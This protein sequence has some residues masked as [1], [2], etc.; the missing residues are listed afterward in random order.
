M[1]ENK[2][3]PATTHEEK[4]QP[5]ESEN[6]MPEFLK[7][8][9]DNIKLPELAEAPLKLDPVQKAAYESNASEQQNSD[10]D[11]RE[12][13]PT[14]SE[15][16]VPI[17]G[18]SGHQIKVESSSVKDE[19]PTENKVGDTTKAQ[20]K[21]NPKSKYTYQQISEMTPAQVVDAIS[22]LIQQEEM[23]QPKEIELLKEAFA[24]KKKQL[25]DSA[26]EEAAKLLQETEI[27]ELRL[28]DLVSTYE[29]KYKE[30]KEELT[31]NQEAALSKKQELLSKLEALV[32][33]TDDF[34][35]ISKSFREI[36]TEWKVAGMV[37]EEKV[38]DIQ[39]KYY[40]LREK[41]YD[42]K[43]LND[44]FRQ[45]DFKKNLEAKEELIRKAEDLLNEENTF[46][47]NRAI[48]ELHQCWKDIGPVERELR[49]DL[50]NRFRE[51]SKQV[52]DKHQ[53]V[54]ASRKEEEE[55]NLEAKKRLCEEIEEIQ[56]EKLNSTKHWNDTKTKVLDAQAKWKTI[57]QVPR[58]EADAIYKRFRAAC[59]VFFAK[60]ALFTKELHEEME[61]NLKLKNELVEKAEALA[62]SKDWKRTS[63]TLKSLQE[64]WKKIGQTNYKQNE[65]LWERFRAACNTFYDARKEVLDGHKKETNRINAE[66]RDLTQRVKELLAKDANEDANKIREEIQK[67]VEEYKQVGR[68]YGKTSQQI[69]EDFFEAVNEVYKKWKLDRNSR[70]MSSY[71]DK[72]EQ[73]FES[74]DRDKIRNEITF[75]NHKKERITQE[76]Q[77]IEKNV[78]FMTSSSKWGNNILKDMDTKVEDLRKECA[79]I[80]EK[81][82]LAKQ[83]LVELREAQQQ[84]K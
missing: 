30:Y 60:K 82:S 49:E 5:N 75:L 36:E 57:G 45:Y 9:N 2:N 80:D 41:F 37:A 29:T 47:A 34:G 55:K 24:K 46:S 11:V 38:N 13:I 72:M 40:D 35:V 68:A 83:K 70:R 20:R 59:D 67:L 16:P 26:D 81:I 64:A 7:N 25:V 48:S 61:K 53:E 63:D 79:L 1:E 22:L 58:S 65:K 39:N 62:G 32:S 44:E 56:Y 84:K 3:N 52:R 27:Q 21:K 23:A 50:W 69:H 8:I 14:G 4:I 74:G 28:N 78:Q 19:K 51:I 33:S 77:N 12:I 10:L 71:N 42:L 15:K 31:R 43:Q 17:A 66:K 54:F 76:I 6:K 18:D 73:F